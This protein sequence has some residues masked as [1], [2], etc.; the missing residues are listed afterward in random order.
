[1]PCRWDSADGSHSV[2]VSGSTI[3]LL[4]GLAVDASLLLPRRGAEIG[5]LLLG[6]FQPGDRPTVW[7]DAVEEVP[8]EHRYGPSYTLSDDDRVHFRESLSR[9]RPEGTPRVVGFYRSYTRRDP[10]PDAGDSDLFQTFIPDERSAFILIE[11][12]SPA[13]CFATFLFRSEGRLPEHPPYAFFSLDPEALGSDDTVAP[14][15]D[16]PVEPAASAAPAAASE[17]PPAVPAEEAPAT[18]PPAP[19]LFP[20]LP[21]SRRTYLEQA[22]TEFETAPAGRRRVW[23]PLAAC[24]LLALTAALGYEFWKTARQPQWAELRL[25]AAATAGQIQLSWDRANPAVALAT[26]GTLFVTDGAQGKRI[27]LTADDLRRGR[28]T[29]Q[30]SHSD[31]L[32]RLDLQ[33]SRI[34]PWSDSLRVLSLAGVPPVPA[35]S[36]STPASPTPAPATPGT[37]SRTVPPPRGA[38][39][40]ASRTAPP[41][42]TARPQPPVHAEPAGKRATPAVAIHEVQPEIP[43]GIRSRI[44]APLV[45]P[46]K[47]RVNA[48]GRVVSAV[49]YS[50]GGSVSRYLGDAAAKAARSWRFTPARSSKGTAV[51]SSTTIHFSFA[52]DGGQ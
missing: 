22:G 19:M 7:V 37:A 9:P 2:I 10:A 40:E 1:M 3:G 38:I 52:P 33:G 45:V 46:V 24:I 15:E 13:E 21:P 51:D 6:R 30:P 48:S 20:S 8:C 34:R 11:P 18:P 36:A 5:G 23:L 44:E 27:E 31:V 47:V 42:D 50:K 14:L 39:G 29:Y 49:A 35:P 43:A 32:F 16:P 4:R 17:P 25:D 12:L 26:R 41:Q 28:L